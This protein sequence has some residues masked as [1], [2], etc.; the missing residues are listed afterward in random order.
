MKKSS[1]LSPERFRP[2][3]YERELET[4]L[5][6]LRAE[7]QLDAETL[8]RIVTRH[9]KPDGGFFSKSELVWAARREAGQST[10]PSELEALITKLRAKPIRTQSGVAPVTVLT[11]PHPC[12]GRC[13]FCP[14]DP[15]VPKSYLA[16]EPGAQRAARFGYDAYAQVTGRLRA[17]ALMGHPVDKI[18]LIILGGTWTA[19]PEAYRLAFVSGCFRALNEFCPNSAET[20]DLTPLVDGAEPSIDPY[21][22]RLRTDEY[23]RLVEGDGAADEDAVEETQ[24]QLLAAL[25]RENESALCRC[26][27][28]SVETRPDHVTA[29][30]L[31]QLRR[32]GVTR[33]QIG[34]QSLS[35]PILELN[36]RDHT[37]EDTR[38]AMALLRRF[39]FKVQVHWMANLLG[40]TPPS[41]VEDFAHLFDD[42][43]ARPDELKIYPCVVVPNSELAEAYERG[44]HVPYPT[45]TLIDV[46]ARCLRMVPPYCRVNRLM[47][48]I[49]GTD[50]LGGSRHNSLRGQVE[51]RV[52]ALGFACRDIR[53]REIRTS[54]QQLSRPRLETLEYPTGASRECFIEFV[55]DGMLCGFARLGFPTQP[56]P[57]DEL[58]DAALLRE[59]HVYGQAAALGE[60]PEAAVQHRGLGTR[61]VEHATQL[62]SQAG[63]RS[64]AVISSV[65]T[66]EYYRRL[67]F[68]D[69]VLYQHRRLR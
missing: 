53:S 51:A 29:E 61:L 23:N 37:V 19:Y 10:D 18:E 69:G 31:I 32:L 34:C 39:G 65:G 28:M 52:A 58:A 43:G 6:A 12:P 9:P 35:D 36:H 42:A 64:L 50:V 5:V 66:R 56:A 47:R 33:V 15:R 8:H 21:G 63:C 40:A 45:G 46:L 62:A 22:K 67:G 26:V 13:V 7:S 68:T 54:T 24:W 3:R 60:R 4:V 59:V 25:H 16:G 17:L 14:S 11:R 49:P 48:D 38:Q 30:A 20:L 2:Q 57:I 55:A 27:G 44:E 41:D 1:W